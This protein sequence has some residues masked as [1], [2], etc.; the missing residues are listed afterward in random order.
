MDDP[1]D[2]TR[3]LLGASSPSNTAGGRQA[4]QATA[5]G[6]PTRRPPMYPTTPVRE[7][8][9]S[10]PPDSVPDSLERRRQGDDSGVHTTPSPTTAGASNGAGRVRRGS[11]SHSASGLARSHAPTDRNPLSGLYGNPV[12][13][14]RRGLQEQAGGLVSFATPPRG[15]DTLLIE[16]C[17]CSIPSNALQSPRSRSLSLSSLSP[18]ARRVL[19][20][21]H[22]SLCSLCTFTQ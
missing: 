15:K 9:F 11:A 17:V 5:P 4:G 3:P 13:P 8:Y 2:K 20:R 10:A 7:D 14:P 12:T 18:L 16:F 1:A 19:I 22:H 6:T 21:Q